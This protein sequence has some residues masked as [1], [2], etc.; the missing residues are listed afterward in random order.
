MRLRNLLLTVFVILGMVGASLGQ[1][2][3]RVSELQVDAYSIDVG[4]VTI[5]SESLA[6]PR[7]QTLQ[8]ASGAVSL[9]NAGTADPR[10]PEI[11]QPETISGTWTFGTIRV[12]GSITGAD[13][14]DQGNAISLTGV[15]V[16]VDAGGLGGTSGI[17]LRDNADNDLIWSAGTLTV[18]GV[19]DANGTGPHDIAGPLTVGDGVGTDLAVRDDATVGGS[20]TVTGTATIE[21]ALLSP[22]VGLN[23]WKGGGGATATGAEAVALGYG[24][25]AS[26]EGAVAIGK[27][28]SAT[29]PDSGALLGTTTATNEIMLG[30][31]VHTVRIPGALDV[32]GTIET[33]GMSLTGIV[34]SGDTTN[35]IHVESWGNDTTGNGSVAAPLRKLQTAIDSITDSSVTNR[36]VVVLGPGDYHEFVYLNKSYITI[37]GAGIGATRIYYANQGSLQAPLAVHTGTIN[38]NHDGDESLFGIY[39]RNL[40]LENTFASDGNVHAALTVGDPFWVQ[41]N[42]D[43]TTQT[44]DITLDTVE[45]IGW[46]DTVYIVTDGTKMTNCQ[47]WG[48]LDTI[49]LISGNLEIRDSIVAYRNTGY[50]AVFYLSSISTLTAYNCDF[51]GWAASGGA[52]KFA[53]APLT[54]AGSFDVRLHDCTFTEWGDPDTLI[55]LTFDFGPGASATILITGATSYSSLGSLSPTYVFS[56]ADFDDLSLTGDLTVGG[57]LDANG[58]GPHDIAGPLTVGDG[59]GTDLTVRDDATVGGSLTVTGTA[60]IED[61]LTAAQPICIVN[62]STTQAITTTSFTAATFDTDIADASGMHSTVSNTSRITPVV[63]GYYLISY[64]IRFA[65]VT[66]N[67]VAYLQQNGVSTSRRF[68]ALQSLVDSFVSDLSGCDLM[69]FNGT[70]DYVELYVYQNSGGDIAIGSATADSVR[71][72]LQAAK[73]F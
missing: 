52:I 32:T 46:R 16:V 15:G 11:A 35:I 27:N 31:A 65:T 68:G 4:Y 69:Y 10:Y 60:T 41:A 37:V 18:G 70:T 28:A 57:V 3:Y 66:G 63:A 12:G 29:Y 23:S 1:R 2:P 14:E 13:A 51:Q 47:V 44:I 67:T 8:D 25:T 22:G 42:D 49:S 6:A 30:A 40:T 38:T 71:T 26:A 55:P 61:S 62:N 48:G 73:V 72:Y 5:G 7:T 36:Y 58:T 43:A 56:R 39:V 9:I 53:T 45:M 54:E 34:A 59:V 33:E 24:A 19:L 17:R 20:L 21:G 50:N 64:R